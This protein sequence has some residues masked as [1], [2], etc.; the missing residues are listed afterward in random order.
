MN[1][2]QQTEELIK[3]FGEQL[4]GP[5][6]ESN[7]LNKIRCAIVHVE[8]TIENLNRI[9]KEYDLIQNMD[10]EFNHW[11]QIL[12]ILKQRLSNG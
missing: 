1:Y 3:K 4:Y 8:E 7:R 12:S 9:G 10:R 11:D 5:G 2:E 6:I